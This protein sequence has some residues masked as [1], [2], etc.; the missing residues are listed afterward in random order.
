MPKIPS[1]PA[2]AQKADELIAAARKAKHDSKVLGGLLFKRK[3]GKAYVLGIRA[4]RFD[5]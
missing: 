5:K 4:K 1:L 3:A 2:A